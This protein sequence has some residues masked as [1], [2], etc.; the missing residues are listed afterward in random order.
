MSAVPKNL[1]KEEKLTRIE[2]LKDGIKRLSEK[3]ESF[4]EEVFSTLDKAIQRV[5]PG[6]KEDSKLKKESAHNRF[7]QRIARLTQDLEEPAQALDQK[8]YSAEIGELKRNWAK[9]KRKL[10]QTYNRLITIHREQNFHLQRGTHLKRATN[11][12]DPELRERTLQADC[13]R[14]AKE[15]TLLRD[16]HRDA[17]EDIIQRQ[18][19]YKS[20]KKEHDAQVAKMEQELEEAEQRVKAA[21]AEHKDLYKEHMV[22]QKL[23]LDLGELLSNMRHELNTQR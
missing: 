18:M 19:E 13:N 20:L 6:W 1:S 3:R 15:V 8:D 17:E 21:E 7:S 23:R 4:L 22:L 5:N 2:Y 14:L 16:Q 12:P 9:E 11:K 10:L